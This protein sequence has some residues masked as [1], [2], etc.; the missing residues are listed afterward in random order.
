MKYLTV[1]HEENT[2]VVKETITGLKLHSIPRNLSK[3][4]TNKGHDEDI[5][6][7]DVENNIFFIEEDLLL[8]DTV[9]NFEIIYSLTTKQEVLIFNK[10]KPYNFT[11]NLL[12]ETSDRAA[13]A[14]KVS[15]I[16]SE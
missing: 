5:L 4:L 12:P 7:T 16:K 2:V 3:Q 10:V 9:T 13:I 11:R 14:F 15:N 8:I 6:I 1:D